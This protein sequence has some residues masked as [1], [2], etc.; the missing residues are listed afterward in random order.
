MSTETYWKLLF[1]NAFLMTVIMYCK[2]SENFYSTVQLQCYFFLLHK[3]KKTTPFHWNKLES[4][5][6]SCNV[7]FAAIF[8]II[9]PSS[10]LIV[11][12]NSLLNQFWCNYSWFTLVWVR[13]LTNSS[14]VQSQGENMVSGFLRKL[15]FFLFLNMSLGQ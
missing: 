14:L 4:F 8:K 15:T 2:L 12:L 1:P 13:S 9:G 10:P 11:S 3:K 7:S 5:C 6:H